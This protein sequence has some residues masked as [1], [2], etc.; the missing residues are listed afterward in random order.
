M[1]WRAFLVLILALAPPTAPAAGAICLDEA[2][3]K[4]EALGL[5]RHAT[6][7]ALLHVVPGVFGLRRHSKIPEGAF[8]LASDAAARPARG[9]QATLRAL[10]ETGPTGDQP[11]HCR[12]PARAAW[13]GE[14]LGLPTEVLAQAP[15]HALEEW[16]LAL[17]PRGITLIAPDAFMNNHLFVRT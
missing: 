2:L 9:L 15:C 3:A 4:A 14:Q 12:F 13:L 17:A 5:A 6:W 8:F 16:Q 1:S 11:T 10:F 7:E